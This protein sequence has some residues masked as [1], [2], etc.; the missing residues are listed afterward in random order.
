MPG[1]LEGVGVLD[2]SHVVAGPFCTLLL[3]NA[4]AR[5]IKVETPGKGEYGRAIGPFV[6][7][8]EGRTAAGCFIRFN[9][10]KK[11]VTLNLKEPEGRELFLKLAEQ[12]D[13]V[14]ENFRPGV[15][16]RLGLGYG[17]LSAR[18]PRIVMASLSGYGQPAEGNMY[19]RRP[20][21]NMVMQAM[22]GITE[23]TGY[24]DRRPAEIALPI[25]DLIPG[26]MTALAIVEALYKR[27]RTGQGEYIDLSM[28]DALSLVSERSLLNYQL[29]GELP[30]RG[31]EKHIAPHSSYLAKDGYF[32]VDCYSTREWNALCKVVGRS[33]LVDHEDFDS[34]S[35]RAERA[36][37]H[38]RPMLEDWAA[39]K[40]KKEAADLL[41]EA[42]VGAAPV[43]NVRDMLECPHLAH[44]EMLVRV[45]DP[46]A[47]ELVYPGDPIKL[48]QADHLPFE[49]APLL[50]E[51]NHLLQEMLDLTG[52]RMEELRRGG[53]I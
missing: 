34:G 52:E 9:R 45:E 51:H 23:V 11:S 10:N 6:T 36:E 12:S 35:K 7:D 38:I 2:V 15:M 40:T 49:P 47:G 25:G 32:V 28:Y 22:A 29:T 24:E 46:V 18:N 53:V 20:A 5:V 13:V 26:M 27:E 42:G 48:S 30:K 4:G 50:G 44:R 1:P 8:E 21:F 14:V 33:D 19:W 17:E 31:E 39:D 16:E 41:A 43:Q 3:A 37:T